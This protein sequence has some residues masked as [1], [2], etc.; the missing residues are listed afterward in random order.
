VSTENLVCIMIIQNTHIF[1]MY[2]DLMVVSV[3]VDHH[4]HHH[5]GFL[6][7]ETETSCHM[8]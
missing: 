4:H 5:H 7:G 8:S 1:H 2:S 3:K 6:E